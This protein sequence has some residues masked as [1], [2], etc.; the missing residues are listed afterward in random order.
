MAGLFKE[1]DYLFR[2]GELLSLADRSLF[3]MM[4][5]PP[6]ERDNKCAKN[7]N[8]IQPM[9]FMDWRKARLNDVIQAKQIWWNSPDLPVQFTINH[10]KLVRIPYGVHGTR[11]EVLLPDTA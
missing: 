5:K 8:Q 11:G 4:C 3:M 7:S 6:E 1:R 2:D 9:G 10:L